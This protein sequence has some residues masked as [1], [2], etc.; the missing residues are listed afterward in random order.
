MEFHVWEPSM[1]LE[2]SSPYEPYID[3]STTGLVSFHGQ[4]QSNRGTGPSIH[5]PTERAKRPPLKEPAKEPLP[6]EKEF[7]LGFRG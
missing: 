7:W 2:L 3:Q 4:S 5:R 1:G 6:L